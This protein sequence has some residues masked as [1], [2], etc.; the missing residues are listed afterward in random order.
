MY[1]P[2]SINYSGGYKSNLD[3]IWAE[4][5]SDLQASGIDLIIGVEIIMLLLF[6][7]INGLKDEY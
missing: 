4:S 5:I 7:I 1:P 3:Q 2:L 6:N